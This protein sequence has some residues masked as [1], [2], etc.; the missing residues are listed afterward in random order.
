MTVT[1]VRKDPRALTMTIDAEFDAPPERVW[2]A[3]TRIGGWWPH[4]F[5]P[6]SGVVLEPYVG[7]RFYEDWGD[8][9]GA[10]YGTVG[11]WD[12][13]S[14][15]VVSGPMGM[16]GP[17]VGVW[18]FELSLDGAR[19]LLR[20]THRAFGDIDDETAQGYRSGWGEVLAALR[21]AVGE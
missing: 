10:L 4:R 9:S 15:V 1:G 12:A 18:S 13:G 20:C 17:V 8:G 6:G 7:G 14:R 21:E 19:T 3:I 11:C 16:A 2:Q 5:R